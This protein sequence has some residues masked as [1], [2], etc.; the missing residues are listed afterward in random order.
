MRLYLRA[1][2]EHDE[3]G[4]CGMWALLQRVCKQGALDLQ[5][6]GGGGRRR[7]TPPSFIPYLLQGKRKVAEGGKNRRGGRKIKEKQDD[8]RLAEERKGL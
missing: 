6:L 7:Q 8:E 3:A 1:P 2:G 4:W 5:T